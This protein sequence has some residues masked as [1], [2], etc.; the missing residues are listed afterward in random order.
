MTSSEKLM[1]KTKKIDKAVLQM[2]PV[3]AFCF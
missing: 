1:C 3:L 2:N